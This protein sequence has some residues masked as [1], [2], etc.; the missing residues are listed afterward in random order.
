[1][2]FFKKFQTRIE[3]TSQQRI[4][5][6][7]FVEYIYSILKRLLLLDPENR[8]KKL[9]L[10]SQRVKILTDILN[11]KVITEFQEIPPKFFI[12]NIISEIENIEDTYSIDFET[13]FEEDFK[14]IS[15]PEILRFMLI[16]ILKNSIWACKNQGK[17]KISF[18][19][20]EYHIYIE[21]SDSGIGIEKEIREKIFLPFTQFNERFHKG[22]GLGLPM[23]KGLAKFIAAKVE[24][25]G[26]PGEG[27]T[28]RIILPLNLRVKKIENLH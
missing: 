14:F 13:T 23:V 8:E 5:S 28:F 4:D 7:Y 22:F 16:E 6:F 12:E 2:I 10:L 20:D 24:V 27:S 18:K 26:Y 21:I 9:R 25:E 1:M 19:K 11:G 15:D 3:N 17:I